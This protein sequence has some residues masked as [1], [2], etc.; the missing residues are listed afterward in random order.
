MPGIACRHREEQPRSKTASDTNQIHFLF[1]KSALVRDTLK[2][3]RCA[4]CLRWIFYKQITVLWCA[5][6]SPTSSLQTDTWIAAC[7][8]INFSCMLTAFVVKMDI[9]HAEIGNI[10]QK[11]IKSWFFFDVSAIHSG[12]TANMFRKSEHGSTT[13]LRVSSF[14]TLRKPQSPL[15]LDE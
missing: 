10:Q 14:I 5:Y 4:A 3:S 7:R 6:P 9:L 11:L 1:M 8:G 13:L 2:P 15:I 12:D